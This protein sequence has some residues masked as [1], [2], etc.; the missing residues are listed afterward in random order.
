MDGAVKIV[1][2]IAPVLKYGVLV[3]ILCQLVVDVIKPDR[4]GIIFIQHPAY[5]VL[6]HLPI[7]D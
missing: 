7:R 6:C 3:L 4:F 2:E 5:P 1:E